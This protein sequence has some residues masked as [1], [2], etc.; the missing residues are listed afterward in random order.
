MSQRAGERS[1]VE[2]GLRPVQPRLDPSHTPAPRALAEGLWIVE[3]RLRFALGLTLPTNTV[4]MALPGGGLLLHAP[5]RVD[6]SMRRAL[7]ELG[8][9]EAVLAPNPFH[10]VFLHDVHEAFPEAPLFVA[11]GLLERV[12]GL[13]PARKLTQA[14]TSWE[15][16]VKTATV[17]PA[18]EFAEI[19]VL[20]RPSR[21]LVLTDLA[22]HLRRERS[23]SHTVWRL[24]GLPTRFGPSRTARMLL[25]R[26]PRA[27]HAGLA[28]IAG[29]DFERIT[30]AHGD[31]ITRDAR[32]EFARAFAPHL[33]ASADPGVGAAS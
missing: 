10:Y 2:R 18:P 23:V 5:V 31:P 33:A 16:S 3:R 20:H 13:P 26:D 27:A 30:V 6:P 32:A 14:P 15:G 25:L 9:V 1:W 12:P 19:A 24:L 22:F 8:R 4:V 28:T 17:G 29:W 21:T 11:P 7:D